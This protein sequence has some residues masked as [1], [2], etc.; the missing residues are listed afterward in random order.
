[1]EINVWATDLDLCYSDQLALTQLMLYVTD[2][3]V[4]C[5]SGRFEV[6]LPSKK[7]KSHRVQHEETKPPSPI[8]HRCAVASSQLRHSSLSGIS[9]NV[10]LQMCKAHGVGFDLQEKQGTVFTLYEDQKRYGLGMVTIGEDLQGVLM[11][12]ARNLF[13]I[14]QE[15]SAPNMQGETNFKNYSEPDLGWEENR[16]RGNGK[17]KGGS[18]VAAHPN[19]AGIPTLLYGIGSWFFVSVTETVH[20]SHGPVTIY[21]LNKEDEGAMY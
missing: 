12:F 11:T 16:A 19:S 6:S 8:R 5:R 1:M 4:D 18:G 17:I 3:N 9:Y 20:T 13:I 2:G 10:L 21:F 7:M 14:H 15:I